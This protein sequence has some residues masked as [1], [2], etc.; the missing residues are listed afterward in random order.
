MKVLKLIFSL[1]ERRA[2]K[3]QLFISKIEPYI[4]FVFIASLIVGYYI[5]LHINETLAVALLIL[6]LSL[7]FLFI[8]LWIYLGLWVKYHERETEK[9][10]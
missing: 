3:W 8:F 9:E 7:T 5:S 2:A 1:S 4:L 6:I 10:D